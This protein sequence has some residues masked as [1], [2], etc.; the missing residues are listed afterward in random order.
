MSYNLNRP[1]AKD[2]TSKTGVVKVWKDLKW[3]LQPETVNMRKV[4]M[5]AME[6]VVEGSKE[7]KSQ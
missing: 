1:A 5:R 7:P 4:M 2:G 3:K 6:Q